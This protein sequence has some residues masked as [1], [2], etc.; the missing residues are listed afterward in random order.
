MPQKTLGLVVAIQRRAMSPDVITFSSAISACEKGR[1]RQEAQGLMVA[2]QRQALSPDIITFNAAISAC[3]KGSLPEMQRQALSPN[4]ITYS[5]AMSA[6]ENKAR[7][8]LLITNPRG[9]LMPAPGASIIMY[10]T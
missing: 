9:G 6:C 4:V 1:L 2:I 5:A 10:N 7:Q 8:I 3:E